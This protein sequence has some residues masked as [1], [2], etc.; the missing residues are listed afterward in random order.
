VSK[1]TRTDLGSFSRPRRA[2]ISSCR[3]NPIRVFLP[4]LTT[5]PAAGTDL[6]DVLADPGY[7]HRA[8]NIGPRSRT[9]PAAEEVRAVGRVGLEPTTGGL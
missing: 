2:T 3:Q 5:M 9:R 7:A 1:V 6:D 8:P 4:M